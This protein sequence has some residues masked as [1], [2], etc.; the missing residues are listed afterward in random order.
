VEDGHCV[1][2]ACHDPGGCC[3]KQLVVP[4]RATEGSVIA[5]VAAVSEHC[6]RGMGI[7]NF[8]AVPYKARKRAMAQGSDG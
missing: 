6:S 3:V 2:E 4:S 7:P 5:A 1:S 8:L